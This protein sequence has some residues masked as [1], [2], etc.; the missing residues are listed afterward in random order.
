MVK[1]K[2]SNID[3]PANN[4]LVV[5]GGVAGIRAALDLAES[6]YMVTLVEAKPNLGG[7]LMQLDRQFPTNDCGICKMLPTVMRDDISE[8]CLRRDLTHPNIKVLTE[9]ELKKVSGNAG[10]FKI[11]IAQKPRYVDPLKCINCGKCEAVCPVEVPNEF[12]DELDSRKAIFTPYPLPNPNTYTLDIDICTQ[13]G[14]CVKICPTDAIDLKAKEQKTN[15]NTGAIILAPGLQVF[16]PEPYRSYSYGTHPN[17]LTSID[18]ERVY[19]GLG[20]YSG[21]RQLV[22]PSDQKVPKNLAFIQCVGSRNTQVGHQYC[23]YACCMYSLKEAMLAKERHPEMDVT[24]FY[25]DMRAFGKNYHE[26]YLKAQDMGINFVRCRVPEVQRITENDNLML[27]IVKET[28]QLTREEYELVVLGV[29]LEAP[30]GVEELAKAVEI[31]LDNDGFSVNDEFSITAT[32]KSGI[33]VCGG[34]TGPKDIPESVT[35]ASAAAALAQQ[36]LSVIEEKRAEAKEEITDTLILDKPKLGVILCPCSDELKDKLDLEELTVFAKGL[37]GVELVENLDQICI[38]PGEITKII[39]SSQEKINS[40]IIGAC[41][42]YHLE[43][44]FKESAKAAG[45]KPSNVE[46]LNLRERL[47]WVCSENEGVPFSTAT[48]KGQLA[49]AHE[50]LYSRHEM[51]MRTEN[52]PVEKQALVVGGG[53]AGM[54]SAITLADNGIPVDLVEINEHLG[55]NL[56]DIYSTLQN[57]DTQKLLKNLI[58]RVEDNKNINVK[59]KTTVSEASGHIGNFQV[60]FSDQASNT[61]GVL[62]LATGASEYKPT[63]YLYGQNPKVL[64]QLELEGFL[65]GVN[66]NKDLPDISKI[67]SIAMIQCVGT[68]NLQRPYCSRVCCSKAIKNALKLKQKNPELKVYIIYQDIMTYGLQEKYYLEAREA[69][70]EF[71]RY[72]P[73]EDVEDVKVSQDK[74]GK[75]SIEHFDELLG[76]NITIEPDLLIL[77]TGI[78]PNNDGLEPLDKLGLEY[79]PTYFLQEANI[80]FRPVD[81]LADGIF[82]AGLVH[83]PRQ[84]GESIVQAQAAAGR[85][86]T[87]LNKTS[88]RIRSDVSAVLSRKCSGCEACVSVCPYHARVM[89]MDEKVAVVIEPLC[90][91][92][93]ACAMVCPNGAAVLRGFRREQLYG[94]IDA[95]VFS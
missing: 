92:C 68:R 71:L 43:V 26:Y 33:Y 29:G 21:L 22:R 15:L 37:P 44:K 10:D 62:I 94:M 93:G 87:I 49:I 60:T 72:E 53:L 80:K 35:E 51:D 45:I 91:A 48:A 75:L 86:L 32:S 30:V 54:T 47:A 7:V 2:E 4:A 13:C 28:G 57:D 12:N 83:S 69:G 89:D 18:F 63:E 24:I 95:A 66:K 40:L 20:P 90:Q 85:A 74:T 58:K 5:G 52:V 23:S 16:D 17:V 25:M 61:Y 19:S 56:R 27:S 82:I 76:Q 65:G 50:R 70:V 3:D 46:L 34:F 9:S 59:L 42:P 11:E 39:E 6:G 55:G 79:T 78:V 88:I 77:S 38:N 84:L 14:E 1:K 81:M 41:T 64:T 73:G 8:C 36:H 67:R 31:K